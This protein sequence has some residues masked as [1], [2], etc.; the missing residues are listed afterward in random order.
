MPVDERASIA[1]RKL[2]IFSIVW[3]PLYQAEQVRGTRNIAEKEKEKKKITQTPRDYKSN[4]RLV[5]Q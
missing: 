3:N 1:N 4:E 5:E 2:N